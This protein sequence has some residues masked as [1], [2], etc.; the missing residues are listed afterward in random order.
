M[1]YIAQAQVMD[2]Y[3]HRTIAELHTASREYSRKYAASVSLGAKDDKQQSQIPLPAIFESSD[4]SHADS[5]EHGITLPSIAECAVHLELLECFKLLREAVV[6]SNQL[7]VLF[8]TL[9]LKSYTTSYGHNIR[10]R[11]VLQRKLCRPIKEH[12]STF[13]ERRK[14]KWTI[15]VNYAYHRFSLWV[16]S[17]NGDDECWNDKAELVPKLVPPIGIKLLY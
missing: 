3:D 17:I 5:N 4:G 12:D 8:D 6:K 16:A 13:Q 15:F 11:R 7:D 1:V 14:V 10:G 2:W 9:P